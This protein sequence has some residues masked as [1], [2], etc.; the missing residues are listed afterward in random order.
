MMPKARLLDN[1][2]V[3]KVASFSLSEE[4][5][6]V[7]VSE[8]S[9]PQ[10][11]SVGQFVVRGRIER[12]ANLND[13]SRAM[14]ALENMLSVIEF[15]E[16]SDD[17]IAFAADIE[18]EARQKNLELD[19]GESQ[20][21]AILAHR[22]FGALVTG[23]KRAIVAMA[24]VCPD[25]AKFRVV[26]LEQLISAI[27]RA[28]GFD[29]VRA[30]VCAEPNVDRAITTCFSC[31]RPS[32]SQTEAAAGLESYIRDLDRR[33]PGILML[34]SGTGIDDLSSPASYPCA[35]AGD[36]RSPNASLS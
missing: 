33:A 7:L 21:L 16:P 4:S 36:Q 11:L 28:T 32:I 22:G 26:C 19:S 17:E 34:E 25:I 6:N 35:E 30:K 29:D 10:M 24:V 3:L 13:R 20:L 5:L 18:T 2:V 12:N 27:V 1:D 8:D 15:I 14:T 31:S 9:P 23:D